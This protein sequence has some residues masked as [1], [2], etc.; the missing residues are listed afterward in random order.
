LLS[1]EWKGGGRA[2]R[3]HPAT[4]AVLP[5]VVA[6]L[7][8]AFYSSAPWKEV[9]DSLGKY[10][11][12]FF[13]LPF[14][15][16]F[17]D[18][19]SRRWG[20]RA[21]LLAMLITLLLSYAMAVLCLP[22][23]KGEPENPFVFKNHITQGILLALAAYLWALQALRGHYRIWQIW[24]ASL[25]LLALG[26][27]LFM[28]QG[29]SGYLVAAGLL[30]LF[31]FQALRWRG[32]LLGILAVAALSAGGYH[33]SDTL[34][35]RVGAT[36]VEIV[37]WQAGNLETSTAKRL[38]FLK[39]TAALFAQHP[40]LGTGT[41]SFSHEYKQLSGMSSAALTVNPHNEYLMMGVQLGLPGILLLLWMLA[42]LWR[43]SYRLGEY[44]AP[45]Q[46]LLLALALG[47]LFNSLLMDFTESHAFA[48]LAGLFYAA[49]QPAKPNYG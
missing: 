45:A 35:E 3:H 38:E 48:Y 30:L 36:Q 14:I 31:L 13:L 44:S 2:L 23:G 20:Y 4:L 33:F 29:R 8:A 12:L 17:S 34:R 28:T 10:R 47:G 25:A 26:N 49:W 18:P 42:V 32:L 39:N 24:H 27:V 16:L 11:G 7:L 22:L 9:M 19:Q 5:L 21:F 37:A 43:A 41:G 40:W 46:G 15:L 1:G 6:L